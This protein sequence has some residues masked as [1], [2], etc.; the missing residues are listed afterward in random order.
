MNFRETDLFRNCLAAGLIARGAKDL[1]KVDGAENEADGSITDLPAQELLLTV[2]GMWCPSC[3]WLIEEVLRRM[4]GVQEGKVHFFS[5]LASIR[6]LPQWVTPM[7]ITEKISSLG[8]RASLFQGPEG[9]SREKRDL[10]LRL[11]MA[12]ILAMN[13]MMISLA[14][15]GGF[16][17]DLGEEAIRYLSYPIWLLATPVVFYCGL[18][19]LR[20]AFGGLRYG[21]AS[22]ETLIALGTLSAYFYSFVQ[23][24]RGSLHLY[25]DTAAMLVT[26]VLLGNYLETQA[27]EKVSRGITDLLG[28]ARQKVRL[29]PG[30]HENGG[31][32]EVW[33][34]ADRTAVGDE[35]LVKK[36]EHVPLDG[37]VL[38]GR[39]EVDE[40]ILTG[41]PRPVEKGPGDTVLAGVHLRK[42]EL[43]LRALKVGRESSLGK[44]ISLIQEALGKKHPFE[45]AADRL[46]RFFVPAVVGLA[47]AT[48]FTLWLRS[49]P[50]E[51]AILRGL[52]VIVISCPCALGIA[53]PIVKVAAL[54][55][56]RARGILIRD[57]GALERANNLDLVVFDKTGTLSEGQFALLEVVAEGK[58]REE[59]LRRLAAVEVHSDHF[60][61]RELVRLAKEKLVHVEEAAAFKE[62]PGRGVQGVLEGDRVAIGNRAFFQESGLEIPRELE[63]KAGEAEEDGKTVVF[64]AWQE[65][66]QGLLVF[67]DSLKPGVK[68][69]IAELQSRHLAAWLVSGDGAAT[70]RAMAREA[71]IE[72]FRGQCLPQE[73]VELVK[74]FQEEGHR[75][76]MVGDGVND[77]A[78]LARADVGFA[79]GT[80]MHIVEEAADVTFLGKDPLRIL[81]ALRLSSLAVRTI[82]QNLFFAFFYNAMAIPLAVSGL[83]NPLIAVMAM[84]GSSLSVIGNALWLVRRNNAK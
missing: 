25:F 29:C 14:L 33:A 49:F 15:Y 34:A 42:G 23:M 69:L 9:P 70:T 66:V 18:G 37:T 22:M 73:K 54:A 31:E 81:E 67:G 79:L 19:I 83:L 59:V 30:G 44:M 1:A 32:P 46:T 62:F 80:G 58:P 21:A 16:L 63:Q 72:N 38:R 55:T 61:A 24:L 53:A 35:F 75:V 2:E 74:K 6:Y 71:G 28:L 12:T 52:T 82:R 17:E 26:L 57:P 60:L 10:F 40:S 51:E 76:G 77:A 11:G 8:Y 41:E 43:R 78:A 45:L 65:K 3:S 47:A 48:V 13:I 84:F 7:E 36:D 5:D 64:F 39:G 20:K 68:E 4:G 27:R 50:L 56:G